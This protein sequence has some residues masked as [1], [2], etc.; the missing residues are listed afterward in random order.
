MYLIAVAPSNEFDRY[1][2]T[3]QRV[4]GSLRLTDDDR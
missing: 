2:S 4:V 1:R 3:F